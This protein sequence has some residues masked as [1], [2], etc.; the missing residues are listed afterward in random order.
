MGYSSLQEIW[1]S[2]SGSH[3]LN[4]P[5]PSTQVNNPPVNMSNS[6]HPMHNNQIQRASQQQQQQQQQ[7]QRHIQQ[8]PQQLALQQNNSM[9]RNNIENFWADRWKQN[10]QS[11]VLRAVYSQRISVENRFSL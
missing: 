9:S 11:D 6:M 8:Q 2:S 7:Q 5:I 4:T 3:A 1:G 10:P